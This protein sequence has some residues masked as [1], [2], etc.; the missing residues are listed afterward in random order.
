MLPVRRLFDLRE[1]PG[2]E[3]GDASGEFSDPETFSDMGGVD[4]VISAPARLL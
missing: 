1:L 3:V 4:T 2:V